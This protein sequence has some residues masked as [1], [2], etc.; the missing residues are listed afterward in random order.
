[1]CEV[2]GD[3]GLGTKVLRCAVEETPVGQVG[4]PAY[5]ARRASIDP[6]SVV[7]RTVA[8]LGTIRPPDS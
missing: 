8:A 1:V 5:L 7:D 3:H 6:A 2:V 4:S